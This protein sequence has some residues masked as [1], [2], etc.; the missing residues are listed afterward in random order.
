[1]PF[2][3]ALGWAAAGLPACSDTPRRFLELADVSPAACRLPNEKARASTGDAC[4][5][6]DG[7]ETI[8]GGC[9][10]GAMLNVGGLECDEA[11][12]C[13]PVITGDAGM[14]CIAMVPYA[15]MRSPDDV[16][17]RPTPRAFPRWR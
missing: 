2:E 9:S 14:D 17:L 11:C 1:M 4:A 13:S 8:V 12:L 5:P 3:N 6:Y 7:R 16:L 10:L 15:P